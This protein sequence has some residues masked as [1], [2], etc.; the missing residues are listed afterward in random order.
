M[1][2]PLSSSTVN[3][4]LRHESW[5]EKSLEQGKTQQQ[6]FLAAESVG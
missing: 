6:A 4:F 3:F 1:L 5:Q 2:F